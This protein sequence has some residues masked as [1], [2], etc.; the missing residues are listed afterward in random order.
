MPDDLTAADLAARLSDLKTWPWRRVPEPADAEAIGI[1]CDA[2]IDARQD[3]NTVQMTL[4]ERTEY[5]AEAQQ[6]AVDWERDALRL[7]AEVEQA[8]QENARLR[9]ALIEA[10]GAAEDAGRPEGERLSKSIKALALEIERLLMVS[11]DPV[12]AEWQRKAG[13]VEAEA[14]ARTLAQ[15]LQQAHV[16]LGE[17]KAGDCPIAL[18]LALPAVQALLTTSAHEH[19]VN[20]PQENVHA[21]PE[22]PETEGR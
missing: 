17:C 22:N 11:C 20:S 4:K 16:M 18:V 2:L 13:A 15:T 7:K 5:L 21:E 10:E 6:E 19:L 9:E 12:A 1:L 3:A 8:Q 14:L